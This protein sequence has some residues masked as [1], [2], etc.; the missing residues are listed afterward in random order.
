MLNQYFWHGDVCK[1]QKQTVETV[2]GQMNQTL[3]QHVDHHP[4]TPD[5]NVASVK[6]V[7]LSGV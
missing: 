1:T 2:D 6:N 3:N 4:R 5:F 7:L